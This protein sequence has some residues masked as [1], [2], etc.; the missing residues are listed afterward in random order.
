MKSHP[1]TEPRGF[2]SHLKR[3]LMGKPKDLADTDIFHKI[4]L[5]PFLAWIGLGADGL[6]SS[7]YGPE[8]AFKALQGHTYLAVL[9]ALMMGLT[10][11]IISAAYRRIIEEFP[12]GGGGYVVASKLLGNRAGVVSGCAL[13]VDYILTITVS[14]AAAGDALFS[15]LPMHLHYLKLPMEIFFIVAL[16]VLNIRGVKESV[17]I[18]APVF[19]VFLATHVI[20]IV[21][22]IFWHLSEFNATVGHLSDGF[23]QG[24]SSL[25]LGAMF[26]LFVHAYSMGGGTY[27]GIEAVS[28]GLPIMREP[29]VKTGKR[30]MVY[31]ALSLAF[32]AAGLLF[33]YL[34]WDVSFVEGKTMNA[35][36]FEKMAANLP[37]GSMLVIVT[38]VSEGLLLVVAAQA[39]FIDGPRVLA[40]MSVDSWFPRRFAALSERLTTGNGIIIMGVTSLI[41]LFYT[42]GDVSHLVVMYSINVF[43]TFSLSI[44]G[45]FKSY[46]SDK[47]KTHRKSGIFIFFVGFILCATILCITVAEKFS[48]GGW[49]TLVVTSALIGVCFMIRTHYL[50]VAKKLRHLQ[51]GLDELQYKKPQVLASDK[52]KRTAA[53]L[54]ASYG[55]LGLQ[56]LKSILSNFPDVYHNFVFI[57]VGVIDSGVFKGEDAL[58][59]LETETEK[60]LAK[61]VTLMKGLGAEAHYRY[62]IGTEVAEEGSYICKEVARDFGEV[63]FFTGKVIFEKEQWFD[64]LLHNETAF[65]LQNNLQLSGHTMVILPAK[66]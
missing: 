32:T 15:F 62:G 41:A 12:H 20:G 49:V 27:T 37:F 26:L 1:P 44:F 33:C 42:H 64:R 57:S 48:E 4:S 11:L 34:L 39:G 18:L 7:S 19:I 40:N 55:G 31:M 45:M 53:I 58:H 54:V 51:V 2:R 25:G 24:Y 38:L 30:T 46:V 50:N 16:M 8:E 29:K 56:T 6:S 66:V 23:S 59:Q 28:N 14:I 60:M 17:V 22:G 63:T 3:A 52:V 35:V 61:Y 10:V 47:A 43:L 21:G 5:I 65:S 13:I 9:V 36:L